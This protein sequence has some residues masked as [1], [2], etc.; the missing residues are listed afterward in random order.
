MI[1][2][3]RHRDPSDF[4]ARHLRK[5]LTSKR[6]RAALFIL[7]MHHIPLRL[8]AGIAKLFKQVALS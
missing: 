2:P 5:P 8:R 4:D 3:R 7:T 6:Y 1:K